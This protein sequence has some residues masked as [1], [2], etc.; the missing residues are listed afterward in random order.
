[1]GPLH[2]IFVGPFL[3]CFLCTVSSTNP[4]KSAGNSPL[5][6]TPLL[7]ESVVNGSSNGACRSWKRTEEGNFYV[8]CIT[9][10]YAL[11]RDPSPRVAILGRQV[12]RIVGVESAVVASR[13]GAN[14]V[15]N[16]QRNVSVPALPP[17]LPMPG[18]L[19]RS[20]SWVASSSG[21]YLHNPPFVLGGYSVRKAQ[22]FKKRMC[23]LKIRISA[24]HTFFTLDR[25]PCKHLA[26][27]HTPS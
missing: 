7:A 1:M 18:V 10:V 19:H 14:G 12:L 6:D 17:T 5:S 20:T 15:I 2:T 4:L 3:S 23:L 9:A 8:Q 11:A 16:H 24:N 26:H 27:T 22:G 13:A 21:E 25:K